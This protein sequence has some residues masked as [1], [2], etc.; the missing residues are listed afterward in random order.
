MSASSA[1]Q[2]SYSHTTMLCKFIYIYF[3]IYFFIGF[4]KAI[5]HMRYLH[6]SAY[7]HAFFARAKKEFSIK[8]YIF[9]LVRQQ[10]AEAVRTC[11]ASGCL[12]ADK[13]KNQATG[14]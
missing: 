3:Y 10:S 14:S 13:A 8:S 12:S 1:R 7:M 4:S 5:E 2:Q 11:L 9:F 6:T